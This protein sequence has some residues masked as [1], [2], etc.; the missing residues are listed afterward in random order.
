MSEQGMRQTLIE[1]LRPLDGVSVENPACPGTPDINYVEGWIECK[2]LRSWPKKADT[3]V[4]LEHPLKD[5]QRAWLRRRR[6]HK[7]RVWVLLQCKRE[8]FL[9]YGEVAAEHLGYV[10]RAKLFLVAYKYWSH[11]LNTDELIEA[12]RS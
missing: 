6:I 12:L 10:C 2:W 1:A 9:F 3:P 5:N 4:R 11:G 7:G 8:W